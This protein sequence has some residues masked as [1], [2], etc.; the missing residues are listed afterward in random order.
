MVTKQFVTIIL[1]LAVRT[2]IV[3]LV[4]SGLLLFVRYSVTSYKS[5]FLIPAYSGEFPQNCDKIHQT[6]DI[7]HLTQ[8]SAWVNFIVAVIN[9]RR[10]SNHDNEDY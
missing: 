2:A 4:C 10:S 6:G 7:R 9:F 8:G 1:S 3:F 5:Y